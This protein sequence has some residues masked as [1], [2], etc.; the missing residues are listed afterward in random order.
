[1]K[2]DGLDLFAVFGGR[3]PNGYQPTVPA[4][5]EHRAPTD[6]ALTL[7]RQMEADVRTGI[8]DAFP[9]ED[10]ALP[11]HVLV[12]KDFA[13]NDTRYTAVFSLNGSR[14]RVEAVVGAHERLTPHEVAG[15]VV[16]AVATSIASHLVSMTFP[17]LVGRCG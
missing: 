12:E 2:H 11:F 15:R 17:M 3:N 10:T 6:A 8:I 7:L 9:V 4:V 13:T 1:M 14:H 5:H 16:T